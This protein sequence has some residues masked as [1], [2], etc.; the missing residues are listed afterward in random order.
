MPIENNKNDLAL[1]KKVPIMHYIS[2][3]QHVAETHIIKYLVDLDA[4][5]KNDHF[6]RS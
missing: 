3:G 4:K 1:P 6:V 2:E 5:L